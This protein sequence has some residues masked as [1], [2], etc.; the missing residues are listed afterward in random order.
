MISA[1][2]HDQAV[3]GHNALMR[4]PVRS[5]QSHW[6]FDNSIANLAKLHMPATRYRYRNA[7]LASYSITD[8]SC[9][10]WRGLLARLI[11][12]REGVASFPRWSESIWVDKPLPTATPLHGRMRLPQ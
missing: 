11:G 5:E 8:P 2:L 6:L 7:T 3:F 10:Y 9:E 1:A 12:G 4:R